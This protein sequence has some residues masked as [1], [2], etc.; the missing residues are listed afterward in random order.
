MVPT[1]TIDELLER[2][3]AEERDFRGIEFSI[4]GK[5]RSLENINLSGVDFRSSSLESITFF[6]GVNLS[7]ANLRRLTLERS[8]LEEANFS[9]ADLSYTDLW[10]SDFSHTSF[11]GANLSGA[12]LH[13]SV[14]F[15]VDLRE[16]NLS[17]AYLQ[18]TYFSSSD[19]RGANFS[20]AKGINVSDYGK[21]TFFDCRFNKTI[22]P[23]GRK[24]HDQWKYME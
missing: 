19:L 6:T 13:E 20:Y 11:R 18:D 3:T 15:D 17:R 1:M 9:E 24:Y 5:I 8:N 4:R 14:M 21:K 16:A 22:M 10:R 7:K 23:D 12:N 2:Y